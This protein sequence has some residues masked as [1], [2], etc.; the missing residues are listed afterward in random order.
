LTSAERVDYTANIRQKVKRT[1]IEL[2]YKGTDCIRRLGRDTLE[3]GWIIGARMGAS[4]MRVWGRRGPR[5]G[6]LGFASHDEGCSGGGGR[7]V[8]VR[9]RLRDGE[10]PEN[11]EHFLW[12]LE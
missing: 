4:I 3:V 9:S 7:L 2:L 11:C 10:D 5:L 8:G 12:P 6:L 1:S